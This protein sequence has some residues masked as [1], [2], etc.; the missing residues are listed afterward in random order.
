[1]LQHAAT[2]FDTLLHTSTHCTTP[3]L[4]IALNSH[5]WPRRGAPW[6]FAEDRQVS[7]AENRLFL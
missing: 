3:W 4:F 2:H 1:M 7:F 6:S 5:E